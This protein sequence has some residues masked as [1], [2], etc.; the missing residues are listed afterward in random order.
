MKIT[1]N[2]Y[3]LLVSSAFGNSVVPDIACSSGN[4]L[5]TDL[6]KFK[7]KIDNSTPEELF[8]LLVDAGKLA[9]LDLVPTDGA[10]SHGYIDDRATMIALKINGNE[11]DEFDIQCDLYLD[12]D[13][14]ILVAS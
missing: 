11:Y 12:L 3:V 13:E 14:Y 1:A 2:Q 5:L 9:G 4:R 6:Q 7:S 8:D 10:D